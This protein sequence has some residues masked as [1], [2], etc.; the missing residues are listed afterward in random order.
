MGGHSLAADGGRAGGVE[1]FN[2]PFKKLLPIRGEGVKTR[3]MG[4]SPKTPKQSSQSKKAEALQIEVLQ[5]Q[6]EDAKKPVN[7]PKFDIPKPLAIA[8]PQDSSDAGY[9]AAEARRKAM[10]RTN[11]GRGTLFAGETGGR[12][13]TRT[14]LGGGA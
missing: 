4:G 11:A 13:G 5:Q 9:A 14:L 12:G 1:L 7:L 6:L 2:E 8:P 10:R 3:V